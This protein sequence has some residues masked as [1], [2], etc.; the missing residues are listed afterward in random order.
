VTLIVATAVGGEHSHE[1]DRLRSVDRH[2]IVRSDAEAI[3]IREQTFVV[4]R[5]A[6][7]AAGDEGDG[8]EHAKSDADGQLWD[9]VADA[10]NDREQ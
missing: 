3:L 8:V 1:L 2:R 9:F 7:F 4:H 6:E 10:V 5:A